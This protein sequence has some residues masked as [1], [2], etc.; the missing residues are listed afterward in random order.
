M[1]WALALVL[2]TLLAA[3]GITGVL[4]YMS[5]SPGLAATDV[6]RTAWGFFIGALLGLA[7]AAFGG[8]LGRKETL[9]PE[10]PPA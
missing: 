3:L 6:S 4:G 7:A 2:G 5:T 10:A 9:N 1:V 8:W